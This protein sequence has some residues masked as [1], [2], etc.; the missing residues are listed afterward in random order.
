MWIR[1]F[2]IINVKLNHVL[3]KPLQGFTAQ[4]EQKDKSFESGRGP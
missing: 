1:K 2:R 3:T 4:V